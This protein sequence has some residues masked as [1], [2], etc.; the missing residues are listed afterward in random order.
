MSKYKDLLKNV[1][2]LT[3]GNFSC[4]LLNFFLVPL[5]TYVLSTKEFGEF[6][7]LYSTIIILIP[8]LS[9]NITSAIIRFLLEKN[10]SK[11]DIFSI[12][13]RIFIKANLFLFLFMIFNYYFNIIEPINKYL[14][15]FYLFFNSLFLYQCF[16]SF[17]RGLENIKGVAVSS[18]LSS[19]TII[20]LNLLF[21]LKFKMGIKGYLYANIIGY[22]VSSFYLL[23][24]LKLYSFFT[25]KKINYKLKNNMIC[26]SKPLI[27]NSISWWINSSSDRYIVTWMCGLAA[28]GIYSIGYKIPYMLYFFQSTFSQAWIIS[29]VKANKVVDEKEFYSTIYKYYNILVLLI[30]SILII[31]TKIL[32]YFLFSK[33][34]YNAWIYVPILLISIF[35]GGLSDVFEGIFQA[36]KNTRIISFTTFISAIINIILNVILIK[37]IGVIGAAISTAISYFVVWI[38]RFIFI[39]HS[40]DKLVINIKKDAI[41]YVFLLLQVILIMYINSKYVYFLEVIIFIL[42]VVIYIKD[43]VSILTKTKNMKCMR[44]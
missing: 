3:L 13:I 30:C 8:I 29:A 27:L 42:L 19:V 14:F 44:N 25:L 21:L 16:S 1:G 43:I 2:L 20:I 36:N 24:K 37:I 41:A 15:L 23:F 40:E 26:Y 28:N 6:E 33:D 39:Q 34:F 4:K 10:S 22:F 18:L 12:T 5:Y 31:L 35:F 9:L 38:I 11:E 17:A 32:S 7:L